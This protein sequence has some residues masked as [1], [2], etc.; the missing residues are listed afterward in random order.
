MRQFF[1]V[2]AS[3]EIHQRWI[4]LA[5][6]PSGG[7]RRFSIPAG[8]ELPYFQ[9]YGHGYIERHPSDWI[10]RTFDEFWQH[11]QR[12]STPSRKDDALR[13]RLADEWIGKQITYHENREGFTASGS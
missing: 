10:Q 12:A 1:F 9:H 4:R 6:S 13:H 2:L 5:S 8:V 3:A 7:G 11:E